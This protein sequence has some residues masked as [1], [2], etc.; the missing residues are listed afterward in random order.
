MRARGPQRAPKASPTVSSTPILS[1]QPPEEALLGLSETQ[2]PLWRQT[3]L[4]TCWEDT[5]ACLSGCTHAR[6]SGSAVLVSLLEPG[7]PLLHVPP[8][9]AL[10]LPPSASP[11]ETG[12]IRPAPRRPRA[13]SG[14]ASVCCTLPTVKPMAPWGVGHSWAWQEPRDAGP[15]SS[16]RPLGPGRSR[17]PWAPSQDPSSPQPLLPSPA[18]GPPAGNESSPSALRGGDGTPCEL[19]QVRAPGLTRPPPIPRA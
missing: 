11:G 12:L 14:V 5:W 6:G 4:G 8:L 15:S 7:A 16:A 18:L 19:L 13:L 17:G 9:R 1:S 10:G 3:V 2:F